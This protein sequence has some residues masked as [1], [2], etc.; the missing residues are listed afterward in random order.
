MITV[1]IRFI[2]DGD[3]AGEIVNIAEIIR[4]DNA[5]GIQDCDS[6]EDD[7]ELNDAVI[8]DNI[9]TGCDTANNDED[10][11][12]IEP[13]TVE[14]YDLSI[15][16]DIITPGPFELDQD[17]TFEITVTLRLRLLMREI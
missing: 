5:F 10:D 2:V 8:D 11:H 1:P 3:M 12:D 9:G 14:V 13:I 17:V 15:Q 7:N 4:A 16:K 6:T